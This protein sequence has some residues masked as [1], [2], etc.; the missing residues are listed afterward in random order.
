VHQNAAQTFFLSWVQAK[1]GGG[2]VK[3]KEIDEKC[4][5]LVDIPHHD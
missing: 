3:I 5:S 1:E 2:D 4:N